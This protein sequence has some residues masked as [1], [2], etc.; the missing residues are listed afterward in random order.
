M[1]LK[2]FPFLICFSLIATEKL[3]LQ[4]EDSS[5]LICYCDLPSKAPFP[6]TLILPGSQK[7]TSLRTHNSLKNDLLKINS[8][9]LTLEKRGVSEG[10]VDDKEF[11]EHLSLTDRFED[12]L[13]VLT[14]LENGLIPGWNGKISLLGQGDG[15]RIGAKIAA[16]NTNISALILIAAGGGWT[17]LQ[18][19]LYSFRSEMVDQGYSPQ[20]I[21]GFLVKARQEFAQAQ[22][23]PKAKHIA[24]GYSYK[25]WDSLINTHLIEDL[26]KLKCPIYSVNGIKDDRVPIESV[27]EMA[28]YLKDKVTFIRKEKMGREIIQDHEI[29]EEA[30][31]WLEKSL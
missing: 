19:A 18:E 4:R 2:I 15:G 26:A 8:C 31:S 14:Q 11:V 12:H 30:I 3:E 22:E 1:G 27:D 24:F 16:T 10:K 20:Y 23:L 7:E 29:Y 17:P 9:V 13:L 28:K 21:H 25:Y 5:E 6:I